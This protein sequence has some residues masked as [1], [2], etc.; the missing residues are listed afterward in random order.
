MSHGFYLP[1]EARGTLELI[2]E[3]RRFRLD[4][5]NG[6]LLND[7]HRVSVGTTT[8]EEAIRIIGQA[9]N[10]VVNTL[11]DLETRDRLREQEQRAM[12]RSE[13]PQLEVVLDRI[14]ALPMRDISFSSD[15]DDIIGRLGKPVTQMELEQALREIVP[16]TN[17]F[18]DGE[19]LT[20][21][22]A[23]DGYRGTDWPAPPQQED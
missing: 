7:L 14:E 6:L 10:Y 8:G 1:P 3:K 12:D 2:E 11:G 13:M 9:L 23:P 18:T 15:L 21:L 16:A 20:V 19:W 22:R 17:G 4:K 5:W